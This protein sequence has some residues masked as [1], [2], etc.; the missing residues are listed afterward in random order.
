VY[1][2]NN[3]L[4]KVIMRRCKNLKKKVNEKII[5]FLCA[6]T[7]IELIV[8]VSLLT[9][10]A[11]ISFFSVNWLIKKSRDV[12]RLENLNVID[13]WIKF[14]KIKTWFYPQPDDYKVVSYSWLNLLQQWEF[15]DWVFTKIW[16]INKK[17][18]D[19]LTDNNFTYS[20]SYDK[21][22]YEIWASIEWNGFENYN[23]YSFLLNDINA[24][25]KINWK[26]LVVWNYNWKI[27]KYKS[28][29]I[30]YL[31]SIPTI[32][33]KDLSNLD[34]ENI[35]FNQ[36][37]A[38]K[39]Y[40]NLPAS[41]SWTIFNMDWWFAFIPNLFLIYM[42]TEEDFVNE[43]TRISLLKNLKEAYSWTILENE[44]WIVDIID[45]EIDLENPSK[46]VKQISYD[47][48]N[49][50]LWINI[51][52]IVDSWEDWLSYDL[53]D[54]ILEADTRFINQDTSW[55]LWFATKQWVARFSNWDWEIYTEEDWLANKDTR[56]IIEDSKLFLWFATNKWVTKFNNA[57]NEED[58]NWETYNQVNSELID[59]DVVDI[60]EDNS[61]NLW[62]ATKKWVSMYDWTEFTNY[63]QN[64]TWLV[65][66]I[67]TCIT[68][69]S[70]NNLWFWTIDWVSKLYIDENWDEYWE[71]FDEKDWLID[72][73]VLSI[74]TDIDDNIWIWTIE[75]IS[76]YTWT[77]FTNYTEEDWLIDKRIQKI[78]QDSD[79]I[80]WFWTIAWL[81]K[82]DWENWTNYTINNWLVDN[83]VQSI[84]EDS[85]WYLWV[86]TKKWVTIYYE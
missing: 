84:Y 16:L 33:I 38:Y 85:N 28:E 15:W 30:I 26:S 14:F 71:T 9:I 27:L 8:I 63:Q 42:W 41:Y 66:K 6:F 24:S 39:W 3:I 48:I 77:V 64:K 11:T 2:W 31:F 18:V 10:L 79:W 82:F 69:D 78:Y 81:S 25:S 13:D 29:D 57:E 86:W 20:L 21:T 68:V 45:V 59:N 53:N 74:Y 65:N 7:L 4:W 56:T 49:K 35:I 44:P 36:K 58:E 32:I 60:A 62:F 50:E 75:W 17:P 80:M 76:K 47:I 22:E 5:Y 52:I 83:D 55:N 37:L 72:K 34:L 61:W 40:W 54:F 12:V 51:P 73:S 70:I 19:I 46:K 67:V 43:S 1:S 23:E